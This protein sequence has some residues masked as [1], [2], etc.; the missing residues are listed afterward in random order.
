MNGTAFVQRSQFGIA[1]FAD[2]VRYPSPSRGTRMIAKTARFAVGLVAVVVFGH[3]LPM[4]PASEVN[5]I[6]P[7]PGYFT[8]PSIA[9]NAL[10]PS[11]VVTAYQDNAHVAYSRDS[12]KTWQIAT[13]TEA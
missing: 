8:E 1:R 11:Q 2:A 12:G 6:T 4:A 13:G 10:D 9:V 5:T 7:Q 3:E